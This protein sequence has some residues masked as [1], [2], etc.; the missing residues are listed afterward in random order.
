MAQERATR[1]QEMDNEIAM[2][3]RTEKKVL[4]VSA[5]QSH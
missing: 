3:E 2:I 5:W 4:T 1:I